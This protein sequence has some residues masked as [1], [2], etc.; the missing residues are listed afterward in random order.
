MTL[1]TGQRRVWAAV[2]VDTLVD[3][4]LAALFDA[5]PSSAGLTLRIG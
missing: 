4:Q 1:W 2:L 3:V 5:L